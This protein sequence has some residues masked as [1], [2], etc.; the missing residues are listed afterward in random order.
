LQAIWFI[1][2]SAA[3]PA[4]SRI[5]L[6]HG[7]PRRRCDVGEARDWPHRSPS[8]KDQFSIGADKIGSVS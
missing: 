1:N 2:A 8:E 4:E 3:G 6:L 5:N 7:T